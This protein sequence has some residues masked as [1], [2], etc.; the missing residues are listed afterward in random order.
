M[1]IDDA[2][3]GRRRHADPV[4]PRTYLR[5]ALGGLAVLVVVSIALAWPSRAAGHDV[6]LPPGVVLALVKVAALGFVFKRV[7]DAHV[8]S[9]Q[10]SS[11]FILL[12]FA[13]GIV[14]ATSD[15]QPSA[16]LGAL[17]AA[18]A[19]SAFAA[20]LAYLRPIKNQAKTRG[21]R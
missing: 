5:L 4:T 14:R 17:E 6:G 13:E 1:H 9:L 15:P 10:W 11:M 3:V 2:A 18:A 7:K 19:A 20:I 8:Y 16:A 21:A 12:F